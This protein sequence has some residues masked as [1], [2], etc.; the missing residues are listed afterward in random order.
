M[1]E[2]DSPRSVSDGTKSPVRVQLKRTKG[3]RKPEGCIVV[4]R[5]SRWG[6]PFKI[7][8]WVQ[9][10]DPRWRVIESLDLYFEFIVN[11]PALWL[12]ARDELAGHDLCCV[13]PL[14]QPCHADVLLELANS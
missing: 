11:S 9:A 7:G 5:P 4:S 8:E 3:W 6:N 12:T 2:T 1:P 13:C 14:D 10:D